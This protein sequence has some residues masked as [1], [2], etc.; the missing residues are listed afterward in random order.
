MSTSIKQQFW[1]LGGCMVV[2][3]YGQG[4]FIVSPNKKEDMTR[5]FVLSAFF[6]FHLYLFLLSVRYPHSRD[7]HNALAPTR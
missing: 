1:F 6:L 2:R 7:S 5:N 3:L 4:V